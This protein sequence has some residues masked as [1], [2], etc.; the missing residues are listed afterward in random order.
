MVS[1]TPLKQPL[2]FHYTL[3]FPDNRLITFSIAIDLTGETFISPDRD[4]LPF[5]AELDYQQCKTARYP[6]NRPLF[7]RLLRI[8]C[9]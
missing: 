9:L 3:R 6:N 4:D 8:C 2:V 7:V 5:W 1:E